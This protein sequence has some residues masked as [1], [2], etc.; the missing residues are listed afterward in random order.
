MAKELKSEILINASPDKIWKILTDFDKYPEWN[1]FIKSIKGNA[2]VGNI[3]V[4]RMEPPGASGMT[5][6]PKVLV[7]ETNK[8]FRWIGHLLFPGLFDGEHKFEL[9]DNGNGTTTFIQS[10]KFNGILIP[11]FNKMLDIN[12]VNGFHQMNAKLK[13]LAEQP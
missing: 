7:F 8:E 13:E 10:E 2:V 1:P 6:K 11:F 3:I 9:I 5:F 4:A 12:T